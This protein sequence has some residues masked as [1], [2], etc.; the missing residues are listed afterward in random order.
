MA[1]KRSVPKHGLL[2]DGSMVSILLMC[3]EYREVQLKAEIKAKGHA[4][5]RYKPV[6]D[7]LN[8]A[9]KQLEMIKFDLTKPYN[10]PRGDIINSELDK[11]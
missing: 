2:V 11:E 5:E 10:A 1:E 7:R 6:F 9:K 8:E 3:V 4:E